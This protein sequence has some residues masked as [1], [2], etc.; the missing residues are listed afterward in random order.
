[1][2]SS[3]KVMRLL[4]DTSSRYIIWIEGPTV[5]ADAVSLMTVGLAKSMFTASYLIAWCCKKIKI[6]K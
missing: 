6:E 3:K 2:Y 1:M 5:F 4:T